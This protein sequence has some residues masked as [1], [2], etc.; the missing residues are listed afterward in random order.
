VKFVGREVL[1]IPAVGSVMKNEGLCEVH[2]KTWK[3]IQN[4]GMHL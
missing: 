2:E 4:K 3:A 1:V